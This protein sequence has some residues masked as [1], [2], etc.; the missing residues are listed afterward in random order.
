MTS[1]VP[2]SPVP[3]QPAPALPALAE[4]HPSVWP[5]VV[6]L[7]VALALFGIATTLVFTAAGLAGLALGLWG[8][9]AELR[10]EAVDAG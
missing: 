7:A 5:C 4:T 1:P 9:I 2:A 10:R 3:A 6:A 8:W